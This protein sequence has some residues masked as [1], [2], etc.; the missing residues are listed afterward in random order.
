MENTASGKGKREN[1]M[2]GW[3]FILIVVIIVIGGLVI[4]KAIIN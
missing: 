1:F 4:L 3:G 2:Q